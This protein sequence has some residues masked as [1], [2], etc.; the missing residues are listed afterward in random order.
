MTA[1]DN[2]TLKEIVLDM[3]NEMRRGFESLKSLED[4][5]DTKASHSYVERL[6]TR[7]ANL[8]RRESDR[9]AV[10][11]VNRAMF[12]KREKILALV[13]MFA[14]VAIQPLLHFGGHL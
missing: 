4:K 10:A 6:E 5:L 13:A 12:S 7:V 11:K 9:E 2:F 8:E 1:G 3:R 14:A